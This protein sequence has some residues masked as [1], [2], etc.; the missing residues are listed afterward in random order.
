MGW[1]LYLYD[2]DLRH[3][4]VKKIL[5]ITKTVEHSQNKRVN[6]RYQ[7]MKFVREFKK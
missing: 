1:F 5:F 4:K 7:Q 2:R 6:K 3:E